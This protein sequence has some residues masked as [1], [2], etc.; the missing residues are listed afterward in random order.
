MQMSKIR[1]LSHFPVFTLNCPNWGPPCHMSDVLQLRHTVQYDLACLHGKGD[2]SRLYNCS[3]YAPRHN[4]CLHSS[5]DAITTSAAPSVRRRNRRL[6][7]PQL[8]CIFHFEC[9]TCYIWCIYSQ[10]NKATIFFWRNQ[11]RY[12][13]SDHNCKARKV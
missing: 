13:G 5:L 10:Q 4:S 3:I 11:S 8:G 12:V 7:V 9:L 2:H 6:S 1:S